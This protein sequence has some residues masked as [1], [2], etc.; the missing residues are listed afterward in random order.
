MAYY[1]DTSVVTALLVP[2]AHSPRAEA[3]FSRNDDSLIVSDFA[4]VEF[5][6]VVS[7]QFRTGRL[8][9]N[10][11]TAVL[12][13]FDEWLQSSFVRVEVTQVDIASAERLA[14]E[15]ETKLSAPDAIHLAAAARL[16]A[17]LLTYDDRLA[18]AGRSQGVAVIVP[19]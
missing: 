18:A 13:T 1:L 14:R 10:D 12:A 6:A 15:F 9:H 8:S 5:A 2:D 7:R 17:R 19:S 16:G 4:A 11:A 3:W